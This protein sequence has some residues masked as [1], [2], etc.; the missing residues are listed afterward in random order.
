VAF[1]CGLR[2]LSLKFIMLPVLALI[3][4]VVVSLAAGY[5]TRAVVSRKRRDKYLKWKPY[6]RRPAQP[7]A[8][9]VRGA[10]DQPAAPAPQDNNLGPA[11]AVVNR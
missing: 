3:L 5:A 11:K 7:P 2:F 6:V 9:L 10:N 8:F 4:I 1:I